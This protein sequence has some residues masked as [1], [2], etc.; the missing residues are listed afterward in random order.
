TSTTIT[1]G[2]TLWFSSAFKMG[3]LANTGTTEVHMRV[4]NASITLSSKTLVPSITIPVPNALI[5]FSNSYTDATATT[6]FDAADNMW[7]TTVGKTTFGNYFLSALPWTVP[8][9]LTANLAGATM[10]WK[11]T[12]LDDSSLIDISSWFGSAA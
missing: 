2:N 12:F 11:A 8:A 6:T 10:T 3:G 7:V 9:G 4:V 5:T 1:P